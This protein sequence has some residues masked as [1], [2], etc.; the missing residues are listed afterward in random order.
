MARLA[1]LLI[2]SVL[3]AG[4]I[5][6]G[7]H[8]IAPRSDQWPDMSMTKA[9]LLK[10]LGRPTLTAL[11][12]RDEG[13][14]ERLTWSYLDATPHPLLFIPVV[15]L[16]VAASGDGYTVDGRTLTVEF[17]GERMTSRAWSASHRGHT[18]TQEATVKDQSV[19]GV[20]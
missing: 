18:Q 12:S 10:E 19:R 7:T 13:T 5:S 11:E 9:A 20:Q 15:G 8:T 14:T 1:I 3:V 16:F 6:T 4:C 2:A 17:R